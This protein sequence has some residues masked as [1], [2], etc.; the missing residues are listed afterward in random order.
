MMLGD[1][2]HEILLDLV[3]IF[4][5]GHTQAVGQALDMGVYN[6]AAGDSKTC[7]QDNIGRLPSYPG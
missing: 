7:P 5:I 6:Y 1:L 4:V 3:G 2:A